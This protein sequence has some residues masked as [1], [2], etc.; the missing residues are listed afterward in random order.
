MNVQTVLFFGSLKQME[1]KV[2]KIVPIDL[3]HTVSASELTVESSL[4]IIHVAAGQNQEVLPLEPGT[5][6]VV[7][8]GGTFSCKILGDAFQIGSG[9][10]FLAATEGMANITP[11]SQTGFEGI[12][13]YASEGLLINRQRLT[14]RTI[15]ADEMEEV[16][17]YLR[18]INTQLGRMS[19]LRA[20]VV[21]SLLRALIL[22]LQQTG[23]RVGDRE[24]KIP[25]QYHEFA[26]LISRYHH[27]PAYYYAER[28]GMTSQELNNLCKSHSDMS[29]AEW[30]GE[31]VL[32]EA[33]DLLIKTRLRP[34]QISDMLCFSSYDT[35]SRWFRRHTGEL[36]AN[37]R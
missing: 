23:H 1:M 33:K 4:K 14:Y 7:C 34:S 5:L 21:E 22:S 28:L 12:L 2:K 9:Q 18:L 27:S 17:T 36:P 19:D 20:K 3:Y 15:S 24:S 30:I 13:I 16:H 37:W 35:F 29:A 11:F 31:Y 10:T 8:T 6:A 26:S 25:P 32:L